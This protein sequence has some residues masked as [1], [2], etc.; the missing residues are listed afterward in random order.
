MLAVCGVNECSYCSYLH[1]KTALER[2]VDAD[3][4]EFLLNGT[5][6]KL[7]REELP[8]LLYAQ[9]FSETRAR[10]SSDAREFFI[11]Y[12]G[13]EAAEQIEAYIKSVF[14][15]NLCCNTVYVREHRRAST[16]ATGYV[17]TLWLYLLCKPI[18]LMIRRRERM[19]RNTV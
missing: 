6:D 7:P 17:P 3:D 14:F 19:Y 11:R 18:S 15:G 1:S 5:W 16:Q 9:H 2:G 10:V 13:E 4:I 12:Y 8:A